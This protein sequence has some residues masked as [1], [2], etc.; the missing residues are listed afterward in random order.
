[1]NATDVV[2]LATLILATLGG[3]RQGFILEVAFTLGSFIALWAAKHAYPTVRHLLETVAAK[4]PW[5]TVLAYLFVFLLVW[6]AVVTLA[7]LTRRGA[8]LLFLGWVDRF[9]GAIIGL[10]QGA[11]VVELLLYLAKRVPNHDLHMMIKHSQLAPTFVHAVPYITRL[12]PQ[13]PH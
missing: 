9:G 10:L 8:R 7:R 5:L 2:I 1:M 4:S 6:A 3:L 13:V 12:F 11:I